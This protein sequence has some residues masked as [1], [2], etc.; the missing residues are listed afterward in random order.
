MRSTRLSLPAWATLAL[1]G[2]VFASGPASAADATL[3]YSTSFTAMGGDAS[4]GYGA[5]ADPDV[6]LVVYDLV[7]L[8]D[9]SLGVLERVSFTLSGWRSF[10]G[11]C[12]SPATAANP[13]GCS[14]RIDGAFFLDGLN[15]NTWP[16]E[17][18]MVSINPV[19]PNLTTVFPPI[20]GALPINLYTTASGSGDITNATQLA[21]I[22]TASGLP[23]HG[24]RLRFS[25]QDGGY[26]GMGGGAGFSAMLWNADATASVTYH[27]T[28]TVV[29][30]PGTLALWLAGGAVVAGVARRRRVA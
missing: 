30:E 18:P 6:N 3:T 25:P 28:A 20:G 17:A 4:F 8:F 9:P 2:A 5:T 23:N 12:T 27:Y 24:I 10:D 7:P 15:L 14:A 21:S 16:Q 11:V 26:F 22:F 29:P 19:L 1:A 13:G